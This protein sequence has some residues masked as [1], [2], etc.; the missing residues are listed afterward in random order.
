MK[1][2]FRIR[3]ITRFSKF[4]DKKQAHTPGPWSITESGKL[5]IHV[6]VKDGRWKHVPGTL[7]ATVGGNFECGTA[8]FQEDY[9]NARLISASPELLASLEEVI[10]LVPEDE[11]GEALTRAYAVIDKAKGTA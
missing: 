6:G 2:P 11:K 3:K 10:S 8:N 5:P 1:N 7:L 4:W 9:A